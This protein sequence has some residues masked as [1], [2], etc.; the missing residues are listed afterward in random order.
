M[1]WGRGVDEGVERVCGKEGGNCY[2]QE[3]MCNI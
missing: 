3:W 1:V 2:G